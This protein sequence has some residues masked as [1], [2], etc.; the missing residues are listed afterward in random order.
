MLS[1]SPLAARSPTPIHRRPKTGHW[2]NR[3]PP[4]FPARPTLAPATPAAARVSTPRG[5][6]SLPAYVLHLVPGSAF[7][8]CLFTRCHPYSLRHRLQRFCSARCAHS[9]TVVP[10]PQGTPGLVPLP[11]LLGLFANVHAATKRNHSVTTG[12]LRGLTAERFDVADQLP[13]L[14]FRQLRPHRHAAADHAVCQEPKDSSR[15]GGLYFFRAKSR[16]FLAA[17][18]GLTVTFGAVLIEEIA[19]GSDSVEV[20]L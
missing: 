17:F 1:P 18:G 19:A 5:L 10:P 8:S 13:T 3:T 9:C 14:R 20:A 15:R 12:G 4:A 16:A 6:S 11:L 7:P 2:P